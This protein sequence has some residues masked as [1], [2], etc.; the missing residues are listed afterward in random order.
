MFACEIHNTYQNR[1]VCRCR[2][3]SSSISSIKLEKY[4]L[5][6]QGRKFVHQ[7]KKE[8]SKYQIFDNRQEMIEKCCQYEQKLV[9]IELIMPQK[10]MEI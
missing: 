4:F 6:I 7:I 3:T 5:N 1:N 9:E 8:L 2:S 10:L